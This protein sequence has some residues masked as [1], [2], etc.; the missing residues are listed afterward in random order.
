[1]PQEAQLAMPV[2]SLSRF[3]KSERRRWLMAASAKTP[4]LS[5]LV[6]FGG[7]LA[8]TVYGGHEMYKVIDVGGVTTLK[9][10]L[11]FLFLANFSWIALAFTSGVVGFVWSLLHGRDE[12]RSA[13][14][15]VGQDRGRHADLQR[16]AEPRVRRVAGDLGGRRGDRARRALRLVL[17]VRHDR[18]GHLDRRGAGLLALRAARPGGARL[19]PAS[20]EE[21]A[22]RPAISPISSRRWGGAYPQMVVLD[23]DS[24][25]TGHAIVTLAARME[26]D[27]D[28]GIIQTLPL[29]IN[30]NTLFARV[31]QFA[32]RIYGPVIAAGLS[33]WMGRDGNYW[34]HN[35]IIRTARLR[36]PL[37]PAGPARQAAVRRAYPQPR[38][39]RGGADPPRR[40]C[41]LHAADAE[42]S[43]E[44]SPPSLIDLAARDR[45]W[46]Q[47]NLQ[48]TRLLPTKGLH[49][50]SRQHFLTGIMGYLASPLWMM[51]L[52]VGIVLVSRRPTSGRN[53]SRASSRCFRHGRGSTRSGRS[54]C[55]R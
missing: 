25:M 55:S 6:V 38:F 53:I 28:A 41:R 47:G 44:E 29:I 4:W 18:S 1:M 22:A 14:V 46:C 42:G 20:P 8:L 39:R 31:Q 34:G 40:L 9:W 10:A 17:P 33:A 49:W 5:R 3:D 12:V 30:R 48:H 54:P 43:Y 15:A 27:P 51:Q 2:Q 45:R 23:A 13:A 52:I 26:A 50:A 19:L 35:A 32:A 16:G 37:R 11:L 7:A 36:R 24:L 21:H